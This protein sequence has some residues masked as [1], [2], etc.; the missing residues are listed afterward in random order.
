MAVELTMARLSSGKRLDG[1]PGQ[2]PPERLHDLSPEG[3]LD[4]IGAPSAVLAADGRI[5]AV[6]AAWVDATLEGG[7]SLIATGVGADYLAVCDAAAAEAD[8]TSDDAP[9]G[10]ATPTAGAVASA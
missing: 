8:A 6:N 4:G 10:G 3:V 9:A 7:G 1:G 5:V 2:R